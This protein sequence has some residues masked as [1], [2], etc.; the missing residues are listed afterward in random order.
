MITETGLAI[1]ADGRMS[2]EPFLPDGK[3]I[4]ELRKK[5][6]DRDRTFLDHGIDR[7]ALTDFV[8]D[9]A[10]PIEGPVL[11][12]GTGKGFAAI[13]LARRGHNVITLDPDRE[14]VKIAVANAIADG[15]D[16]MIEFHV[17]DANDIPFEDVSFNLVVMVNVLHH[18]ED[19]GNLLPEVSR[20]LAPGGKFL[21][22]DFT[23]RGFEILGEIHG[24]DGNDHAH[25]GGET[26]ESLADKLKDHGM[27][28]IGRDRRHHQ[29]LVIA[30][31]V[32]G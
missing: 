9:S 13:E 2:W 23:D 21:F 8:I 3:T 17:A 27:I 14:V 29:D 15:L 28:C 26:V 12:L 7:K 31:K 6:I 4:E 25:H 1:W 19:A 18:L 30:E 20:V 32:S 10:E 5:R 24:R 16:P 22:C 11:D